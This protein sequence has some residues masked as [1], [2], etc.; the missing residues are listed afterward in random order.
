MFPQLFQVIPPKGSNTPD[1]IINLNDIITNTDICDEKHLLLRFFHELTSVSKEKIKIKIS[2][3]AETKLSND[4]IKEAYECFFSTFTMQPI[5]TKNSIAQPTPQID[6]PIT[7]NSPH[8]EPN[9]DMSQYVTIDEYAEMH[10]LNPRTVR[11]WRASTTWQGSIKIGGRVY[12]NKNAPPHAD[13]RKTRVRIKDVI[14]G[15]YQTPITK[16]IN[17][18]HEDLQEYLREREGFSEYIIQ[19]ITSYKEA[20]YYRNNFYHEVNWD[21]VVAL[22]L[23]IDPNYY[24]ELLGE[25]N[26]EIIAG[27]GSSVVAK[28]CDK[29]ITDPKKLPRWI[30]HHIGHKATSPLAM[31]P[32][33][34]HQKEKYSLFHKNQPQQS[35]IDR[36][37]F[38]LQKKAFWEKYIEMYDAALGFKHIEKT[39]L[40]TIYEY[41]N[42]ERRRKGLDEST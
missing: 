17:G 4:T 19:Y 26:R 33:P 29:S 21:G 8:T 1:R 35:Q 34:I 18:S 31:V 40:H 15:S 32:S 3:N 25:T 22:I 11:S 16:N 27:G 7:N 30:L 2:D 12:V 36:N 6:S 37:V 24:C 20:Y 42:R 5:A 41:K 23:D 9:I 39:S 13:G 38:N 28:M 10:N 14:K